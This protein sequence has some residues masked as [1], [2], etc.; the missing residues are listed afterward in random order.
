MIEAPTS[1]YLHGN[2]YFCIVLIPLGNDC[3]A[4]TAAEMPRNLTS[5]ATTFRVLSAVT[6]SYNTPYCTISFRYCIEL[7]RSKATLSLLVLFLVSFS[8]V[9]FLS[10]VAEIEVH[11]KRKEIISNVQI[12]DPRAI[13]AHRGQVHSE[14]QLGF[15]MAAG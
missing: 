3:K 11:K 1:L 8:F 9:P 12:Q 6:P 7:H 4:T 13:A 15:W 5:K 10:L 2:K 14:Y